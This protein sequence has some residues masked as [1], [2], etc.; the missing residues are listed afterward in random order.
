MGDTF[1]VNADRKDTTQVEINDLEL[2]SDTRSLSGKSPSNPNWTTTRRELWCFYLYYIGNNGLSGFNFG[3]SQFQNL[4]YLAGYD[5]EQPPF[6][7]TCGSGTG[8]VLP[9]LGRVRDIN[10]I[11]L[12]TNGISFAIQAVLLLMI[13]AWADYGRWRPNIT[14]FF[15]LVAVG[16]SF[17]WLGVDEPSQWRAGIA[18]YVLGLITYQ[19][20]LTFWTAAF[21]GLARNLPEVE[22]S[23]EEAKQGKKTS[24][25]FLILVLFSN[26]LDDH[27]N[28]ESL[29]RNRISNMSFAIC[30]AGEIVVLAIM[31]GIIKG[32][33]AG[34]STENNTKSFSV[35]IAFSGAVWLLCAI[36]WFIFEK[37]RPGLALPPGASLVT[38]GFKQTYV[39]FREC[40]RLK[41]T[42]LYLIFYFLMGDVL[43]T[44]VTVIGTLQ[45]SVV[46][47]S[48]LQLTLLLLVGI[49]AQGIGIY[50]F[51]LVQK[52]YMIST[53]TM[54]MFNVFWILVLTIWGL[55]GVHTDK[56]GFK[57]IWEIWLYQVFYGL[58]VCPWYAYSQT[59]ISEVSPLPQMFLFFAL[60]SVIGKTSAFIGPFVSEAI[61]TASGNNNNMPFAFLFALGAFSTIF[62]F[63][64]DME[65]SRVECEEFVAA[66]AEHQ[67]FTN[68][69]A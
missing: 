8:C 12:L 32:L 69:V 56:F 43:N 54:L 66:E 23:A 11:V 18:L 48:T 53:K 19:C 22:Q 51:W 58:M 9:Y 24:V 61:I 45:N 3:P 52:K 44:T 33:K 64:V 2:E 55:I 4:L 57:H 41:Q 47:Y 68:I 29:A 26:S 30:S 60:F 36:P 49:V 59:M 34:D 50:A 35:L 10:S 17:A 31:V 16:V 38:I 1:L 7:A 5:P 63:L 20:A 15:T 14:I 62:L 46:S 67:A 40:L 65:K 21:P 6:T 28:F 37:R 13:G 42:F 25:V 39:A 27:A